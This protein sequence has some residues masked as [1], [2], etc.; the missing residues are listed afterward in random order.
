MFGL[1]VHHYGRY[2]TLL[3]PAPRASSPWGNQDPQESLRNI[4][5]H[6]A[7]FTDE[8][9]HL[10][11]LYLSYAE[12]H[13]K[14]Q[15]ENWKAG[16]D[17]ILVFT[18]LFAA[19]LATF[20][21][22][23]YK[24]LLPNTGSNTVALLT[25][26]SQQLSNG[27][28][29]PPQASVPSM[30]SFRPS[31]SAV[32]INALW[33]LSLVICLFCALLA[34]LQQHWARRYLHLTQPQCAIHKR[35]RLRSF[36]AEGVNRFHIAFAVEAI[37]AL[38]HI[39][40]FL[41]LTGLVISLFT[42]HHTI[43]WIIFAATIIGGLVYAAITVMP[44][45][46]HNSPYHSPLS[47]LVW[48]VPRKTIK[49]LLSATH[50][51]VHFLHKHTSII[52]ADCISPVST[53]FSERI[54][55]LSVSMDKAAEDAAENQGSSIDAQALSWTLDKSDEESELEKFVAGIPRFVHSKK[56]EDPM[57]VLKTAAAGNDLRP[58]LYRV[59]TNL[60][61]NASDPGLLP[62]YKELP[63][64]V[65]QRRIVN[66]LEALYVLP[67]A[68][69]KILRRV[70]KQ[71]GNEKVRRGFASVLESVPSWNMALRLSEEKKRHRKQNEK[72]ESVVIGARCMAAVIATRLP[73]KMSD[74]IL[75]R[76]LGVRNLEDLGRYLK[77]PDSLR[78][79]NLN[80]F[81]ANTALKFIHVEGTDIL[82]S[83]VRVIKL[84]QFNSAAEELRVEF[85]RHFNR[86]ERLAS[87]PNGSATVQKNAKEL[88][89]ELASLRNPTPTDGSPPAPLAQTDTP[90]VTPPDNDYSVAAVS[91]I[92]FPMPRVSS[93]PPGDV[94]I[95]CP[96]RDAIRRVLSPHA[97][98]PPR[99]LP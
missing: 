20:V 56:V 48:D 34:T 2:L 78:L 68:I 4:W 89:S 90:I 77:S 72:F 35:A 79:K 28:Q 70:S 93:Q 47:A 6:E 14:Q 95:Q 19:A 29:I 52:Q 31:T 43:A 36:F 25:Q 51:T 73:N 23:S 57:G 46:Y 11:S 91:P 3:R 50:C 84:L 81:L 22:D 85:E 1:Y 67:Q 99:R 37:P 94:P 38:L 87:N 30:S 97:H 44:V 7:Q 49:F 60:L 92:Q 71:L 80:H 15:T 59:I 24:S 5:G 63:R 39:S 55:R 9:S 40:V 41:F 98:D 64:F 8:S 69:E 33:F 16:A 17:G 21:I 74:A 42:I 45:F 26:I 12:K 88:L 62:D 27:S 65:R 82:L 61:I 18:G 76:Q 10:F 32:W 66:C 96:P 83:T 58:S 53:W 86:I 13:D 54:K 75:T